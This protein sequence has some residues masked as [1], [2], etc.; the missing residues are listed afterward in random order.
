MPG[1]VCVCSVVRGSELLGCTRPC[2]K[3]VVWP[4]SLRRWFKAPV[5]SMA[6]FRI[7]PLPAFLPH[8]LTKIVVSPKV[9]EELVG[10]S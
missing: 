4:S 10:F 7:P 9:K 5:I 2:V 3:L 8:T 1:I 6:W